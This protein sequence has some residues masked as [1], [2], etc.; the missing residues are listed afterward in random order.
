MNL[1]QIIIEP[2]P[3]GAWEA[4]DLGFRL[5][6]RWYLTLFLLWLVPAV[7]VAI[8]ATILFSDRIWLIGLTVWFFKPLLDRAPLYFISRAIFSDVPTFWGTIRKLLSVWQR[9][10]FLWQTWRRLSL[11]RSYDVPITLLEGLTGKKR[12][13]RLAVLH[14][15][16]SGVAI[17]LTVICVI[18]ELVLFFGLLMFLSALM[19]E[20]SSFQ[21]IEDNF[22]F[23]SFG[24][25]VAEVLFIVVMAMV[26]PFYVCAGFSLYINRRIDLEAWDVE[27]RFRQMA[28]RHEAKKKPKLHGAAVIALACML[29]VGGEVPKAVAQSSDSVNQELQASTDWPD[30]TIAAVANS[31]NAQTLIDEVKSSGDFDSQEQVTRW[32]LRTYNTDGSFWEW[33]KNLFSW[34]SDEDTQDNNFDWQMP[35]L[36]VVLEVL[37]WSLV[38]FIVLWVIYHYRQFIRTW[39]MSVGGASPAIE[40][41]PVTMLF[42]LEV[43]KE[44]LPDDVAGQVMFLCNHSEYRQALSLLYRATLASLAHD[45]GFKF[46]DSYTEGECVAVV[47]TAGDEKLSAFTQELTRAWQSLAYGHQLPSRSAIEGLSRRWQELFDHEQ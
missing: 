44:S 47:R 30:K 19:P 4:V 35:N 25:W 45:H 8:L 12:N 26:A 27:L 9:D 20:Y 40:S 33:L 21:F 38:I 31:E 1:E 18:F 36:A 42:G 24:H 39:V 2:R 46:H 15:N 13:A 6:R 34:D 7:P 41:E 32:R 17:W 22:I 10:W 37:L 3:R 23:S 16:G 5:A 28:A 14:R 29:L 11:T 43:T